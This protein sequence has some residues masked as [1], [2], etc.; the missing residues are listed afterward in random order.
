MSR[1]LI[2]KY[3]KPVPRY[4]SY[5]TAPHFHKGID[6]TVYEGWLSALPSDASASLYLHL[7]F[8]DRLCWFCGCHTKQVN[9]YAPVAAYLKALS[10]EVARIGGLLGQRDVTAVHWGGGSP[11]L[12]TP[13]DIV[14][15]AKRVRNAFRVTEDAEFSVEL[16]PNDMDE[17]RFDA[18][19]EAGLTR[20]SIGVQDFDPQVQVAINRIQ[21]FEQTQHVVAAVR[22]RGVRSVNIDMLYG[23]PHQTQDGALATARAVM[24]MRPDRI[25]LFGYAHVPWVKKHQNM[26]DEAALPDS[27]A[28]YD[29]SVAAA[30]ELVRGGYV[31]I[32]MDHFALPHD[33]MAVAANAGRLHRNFQG[34]T[35]DAHDALIGLGASAI[36]KLPQGY[37]QN[38]VATHEYQRRSF[39]GEGI[40]DR[41][42]AITET[43]APRGYAIERL[44]CDFALDFDDLRQR[45]G[46]QADP[47]VAVASELARCDVDGL[48]ALSTN[49][50][51]LSSTGRPFV[52]SIAAG[53]DAYLNQNSARYSKAV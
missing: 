47:V 11:S 6:Q 17:A 52:R 51:E 4:T 44:M 40:V 8:C 12:M 38:V 27:L 33:A 36:G 49:G 32:G 45:F 1:S 5:P 31:D 41:G 16:D 30:E 10:V 13:E 53:F 39:A 29:Q 7:P 26:I 15:M 35:V 43:D 24:S 9:R 18:W 21:T 50:I 37:V 14:A 42:V 46:Q 22:A 20:A 34:Y 19:A 48:V 28:R 23:L 25:A 2:A 3:S